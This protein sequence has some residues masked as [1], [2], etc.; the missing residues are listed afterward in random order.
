VANDE[1]RVSEVT[2]T[3]G[4]LADRQRQKDQRVGIG[5]QETR[6]KEA[7]EGEPNSA[8]PM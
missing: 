1:R 6:K 8:N 2:E 3:P 5:C 4:D 7:A